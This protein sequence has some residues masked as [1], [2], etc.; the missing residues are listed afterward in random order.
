MESYTATS[1]PST[2]TSTTCDTPA[3]KYNRYTLSLFVNFQSFFSFW[4]ACDTPSIEVETTEQKAARQNQPNIYIYTHN[5]QI[6]QYSNIHDIGR[7]LQDYN[8]NQKKKQVHLGPIYILLTSTHCKTC[9]FH[10]IA[11]VTISSM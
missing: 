9:I 2:N 7:N 4:I 5:K 10:P 6:T 1:K 11:L 8:T 3:S